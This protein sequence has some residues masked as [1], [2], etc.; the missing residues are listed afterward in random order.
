MPMPNPSPQR[1]APAKAPKAAKATIHEAVLAL[2]R[3][4][5]VVYQ[6]GTD[7]NFNGRVISTRQLIAA[8]R[9]VQ[10]RK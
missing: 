7:H 1:A 9:R 10:S 4:G 6:A 3:A 5:N 2:R 8:A